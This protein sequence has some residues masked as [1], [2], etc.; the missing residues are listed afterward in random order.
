MNQPAPDW[1]IIR[2]TLAEISSLLDEGETTPE[3]RAKVLER[4]AQQFAKAPISP[5][6]AQTQQP[7]LTFRL[8]AE[9]YALSVR[10]VRAIAPLR[11]LTPMP[12]VPSYYRGVTNLNGRITSILDLRRFYELDIADAAPAMLIMVEGAGLEIAL[13]VESVEAVQMLPPSAFANQESAVGI[14]GVMPTGLILLDIDRLF[15]DPRLRIF[16]EPA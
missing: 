16:E 1:D 4:R 13:L 2:E 5:T 14:A 3:A 8:A 12:C 9:H 11:R 7:Y 10:H 15:R 6:A